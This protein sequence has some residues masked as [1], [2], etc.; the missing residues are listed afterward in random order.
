[1]EVSQKPLLIAHRGASIL[2]P[3]NTIIA[4][5]LALKRGATAFEIDIRPTRN[6]EIVLFHDAFLWRHF[7][8]LK[9]VP[10]CSL[11]E[12]KSLEFA[13]KGYEYDSKIC[14]LPEFFEEFKNTVPINL[15]AKTM[16]SNYWPFAKSVIRIIEDFKMEDQVWI[17]SFNPAFLKLVKI[18][19]PEQRTGYLFRN[20]PA[21]NRA[22]D[23]ILKTEAWHP[24][25]SLI[26]DR[27]VDI[28]KKLQKEVYVWTINEES[29]LNRILKYDIEG[30]ITDS[31]F[32]DLKA[33]LAVK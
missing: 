30:V 1:V 21:I 8:K 13:R 5:N 7:R 29:I 20:L 2:A 14:T 23:V 3:E 12:L 18:F 6:G 22:V 28:T 27:F 32:P 4:C 16:W 33:N 10:F 25:H 19:K 17:S 26:S 11:K 15:D 24:H 31:L 9:P